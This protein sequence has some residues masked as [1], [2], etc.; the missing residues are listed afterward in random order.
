MTN[1][2]KKKLPVRS[3]CS[4]CKSSFLSLRFVVMSICWMQQHVCI[5]W[6]Q[7]RSAIGGVGGGGGVNFGD[8]SHLGCSGQNAIRFSREGLF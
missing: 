2:I 7:R 3:V 6:E 4:S 8:W 1:K 5:N